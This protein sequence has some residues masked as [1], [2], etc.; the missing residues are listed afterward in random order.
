MF[1][2]KSCSSI[3]KQLPRQVIR[4]TPLSNR[5]EPHRTADSSC[6]SEERSLVSISSTKTTTLPVRAG[7]G[8]S[9]IPIYTFRE[10][11][12]F[13]GGAWVERWHCSRGDTAWP[14]RCAS[15]L[16]WCV[17]L[18]TVQGQL[19]TMG[20]SFRSRPCPYSTGVG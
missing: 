8:S 2:G 12:L 18:L 1:L 9:H 15:E 13:D 11:W 14:A 4:S 19:L 6:L 16:S 7:I 17:S 20:I 10:R 5:H 3:L